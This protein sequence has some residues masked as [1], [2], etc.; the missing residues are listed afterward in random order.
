MPNLL[1]RYRKDRKG[2]V[3]VIVALGMPVLIGMA[4]LAVDI[5]ALFVVRSELQRAADAGALAGASAF[6]DFPKNKATPIATQRALDFT[7]NQASREVA[8]R[9]EEIN[10]QV[11][12]QNERVRV[13]I[14][15]WGSVKTTLGMAR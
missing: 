7:L 15:T 3:L 4:G 5:G 1:H 8:L 2:S 14:Q 11:D 13:T 6:Q 12:W 10:V 9:P